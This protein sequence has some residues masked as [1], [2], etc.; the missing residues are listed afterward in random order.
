MTTFQRRP[1]TVEAFRVSFPVT[2]RMHG[3][4]HITAGSGEWVVRNEHGNIEV[5]SDE[6]FNTEF[7]SINGNFGCVRSP[8][9]NTKTITP[10]D[11]DMMR[12]F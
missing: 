2:I 8:R 5:L 1:V 9:I 12:E 6:D 7:V 10:E 11:I 4:M 3:D